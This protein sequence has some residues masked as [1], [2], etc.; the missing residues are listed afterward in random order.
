VQFPGRILI[1]E[2]FQDSNQWSQ[3]TVSA[4]LVAFPLA[5]AIH[6]SWASRNAGSVRTR[7]VATAGYN[8]MVQLSRIISAQIYRDDD[9]PYYYRGN[10]VLIGIAVWNIVLYFLTY[11]YYEYRNRQRDKVWNAMSP[12]EQA[13][14][15]RGFLS[16]SFLISLLS[17]AFF[18]LANTKDEGSARLDFRFAS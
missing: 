11:G 16:S 2:R 9:K 8:M 14:Y 1:F 10:K 18:Q 17:I 3:Y 15:V 5:H 4:L 6:A 13:D 12:Q 7:T